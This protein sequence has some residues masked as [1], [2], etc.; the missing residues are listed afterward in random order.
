MPAAISDKFI[1]LGAG[2]AGTLMAWELEKRG[3][4]YEGWDAP[5]NSS[6]SS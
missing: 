6:K 5:K 1:I 4:N 2:L 3:V